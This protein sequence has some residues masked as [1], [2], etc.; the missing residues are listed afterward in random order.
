MGETRRLAATVAL[1]LTLSP[2]LVRADEGP[3]KAPDAPRF[4]SKGRPIAPE[5]PKPDEVTFPERTNDVQPEYT[6]EAIEAAVQGAVF[7]KLTVDTEGTV[8]QAVVD[9]GL[10]YGLDESAIAA[11]KQLK[12]TPAKRNGKPFKAT[13]RYRFDFTLKE[14]PAEAVRVDGA[15]EGTLLSRDD[16]TPVAG[17]TVRVTQAAEGGSTTEV[18]TDALGRFAVPR[19][20]VGD[21]VVSIVLDGF[22]PFVVTESIVA[23]ERNVAVYRVGRR[24]DGATAEKPKQVIEIDVTGER[25]PREVTRRTIEKRE[26][27][28]IP[29]TNGDALRAIQ[30]LPGVARP[31]GLA[32]LLLVR[33]SAPQD[34][35]TFI[36]GTFVPLIYHFGGL[37][38]VV[39]TELINKI[40]FY[41]GNF[42]V[43]YGRAM[44]GIVD[45]GLRAPRTD[46]FHGLVQLD[47]IDARA[48]V[49]G[50]IPETDGKWSYA[51]AA[52]RSY[53]DA[54]LGPVLEKAGAGVTQAPVYYDYQVILDGKPKPGH[55]LRSS[56][57]GSDDSLE[58]LLREPSANEP[59][60][61]GNIGLN[62]Q[63]QRVAFQYDV[64]LGGGDRF[65]SSLSLGRDLL[66][67][68]AGELFFKIKSHSMYG[69][70]EYTK[71]LAKQATMHV[72]LDMLTGRYE[73][74]VRLPPPPIPGQPP[75]QPFSTRTA[76]TFA[77]RG[78][79]YRP[80]GYVEVELT[81]TPRLRLVPGFRL[82]YEKIIKRYDFSPRLNARYAIRQ[83]FPKTTAK[84]GIGVFHQPPQPQQSLPPIGT[85]N[86]MSNRAIHYGL[87][88]EQDVTKQV[89]LS[90]EAF[91]KQLDDL[92]VAT[93][94]PS[95]GR[96]D[97][98]N[99]QL[100]YVVGGE[101]LLKYKADDRFFGWLAYTLSR[102]AR[103]DAPDAPEYLVNFDQTH[104]LTMLGSYRLGGGWELGA[105]FRLISGSLVQ[106]NV[107]DATSA[108]CDPTRVGGLF[109]GATGAYTPIPFGTRASER[110]PM[111]HSL[112]IRVD[113]AWQFA[114]W[115]LSAYLDVQNSYNN[116]NT[117]AISY[118]FNYTQRQFVSGLPILPSIGMRGDW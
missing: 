11:A 26:L 93:P 1:T 60:I 52:R 92:V 73:V 83:D 9:E 74:A 80:A 21:Y 36:D 75:N 64:D 116:Q 101:L 55:H 42:S 67:F 66:Q 50:P 61:S 31:P 98:A 18:T 2:A 109:H 46:G 113:K 63:F 12:F 115:K 70:A 29:G 88:V 32:G 40:D 59:A 79:S 84:F 57:Y 14:K 65:D 104:I 78:T 85:A 114:S 16:E 105:R 3:A 8:V 15:L 54:W 81:P 17:A 102:S 76:Q 108:S 87:G 41:P 94:S 4:D 56:Y 53:L 13:F 90:A 99:T 48:L 24:D 86:L 89:E 19:L 23:N 106:P 71:K 39:P 33:G 28:R 103:Q 82:D 51:V 43:R 111:F 49:E 25:P 27:E 47:L 107:C 96:V 100:G 7:L 34:T 77:D 62:T 20:D 72:G 5:P 69:R 6:P 97:Y 35:Q 95:G 112:D 22:E 10:G 45:A 118:N 110:L 30:N 91:Y 38:S 68:N 58:L 37:S 44:G 117:E